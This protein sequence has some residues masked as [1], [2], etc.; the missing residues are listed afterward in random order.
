[1]DRLP[2]DW[3]LVSVDDAAALYVKRGS[4]LAAVADSFGYAVLPGGGLALG[5]LTRAC[6]QDTALARQTLADLDRARGT[7]AQ[8]KY[9]ALRRTCESALAR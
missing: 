1:M 8:S 4:A 9:E 7:G 3:A 2:A 5:D 6:A